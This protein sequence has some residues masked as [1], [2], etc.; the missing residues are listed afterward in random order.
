MS[1]NNLMSFFLIVF[2]FVGC[3]QPQKVK[4]FY[5]TTKLLELHNKQRTIKS[6]E[7]F[8][9]NDYL[10]EYAQK[11][12]DWMAKHNNLQHSKIQNLMN[13]F[14]YVGENIAWNQKTE[15]EVVDGWMHSPGHK[16][17]IL[18]RNFNKIGFGLSYNSKN[19]PYWCTCF[20]N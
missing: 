8:E 11:H 15:E 20:G 6:L 9:L 16:A 18:N 13:K 17:N 3:G 12:S 19:E 4:H 2:C 7:K 5:S 10:C 14:S 1:F